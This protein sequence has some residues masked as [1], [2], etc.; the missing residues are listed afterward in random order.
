MKKILLIGIPLLALLFASC[1][2]SKITD[3]YTTQQGI[4]TSTSK[5]ILVLGL[6]SEKNRNAKKAMEEQL[7]VD[8]Q[9]FGYNAV[10]ATDEF[11]P[12]AFRGMSEKEA[13]QKLQDEGIEQVV[14]I[15]LVDKNNEKRYVP[16]SPAYGYAPGFWG[17]YS[18]Y[19]PW[20]YRPY[21]RPGHTETTT[22]YVFETNL[23]DV[24]NN[25]LLYSA[26]SQTVDASTMG[27]LAND[28]ARD[29]VKD[30]R[31]KNVLG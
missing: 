28:Y 5:K 17:Y 26:Q 23:Y 19:S 24:T 30:M 9:K 22:K 10:A 14:T 2:T 11:G 12:T 3:S 29:I 7:A 16:S 25:Q 31:K 8:L 13:L 6:F 15:N 27:A 18:Y 21:Y 20:A 4:T 1:S